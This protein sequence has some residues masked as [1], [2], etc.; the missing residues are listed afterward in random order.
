MLGTQTGGW[1]NGRCKWIHWAIVAPYLLVLP[2]AKHTKLVRKSLIWVTGTG[3]HYCCVPLCLI[4]WTLLKKN[5]LTFEGS[6]LNQNLFLNRWIEAATAKAKVGQSKSS[7]WLKQFFSWLRVVFCGRCV[8]PT[9]CTES[10]YPNCDNTTTQSRL[11]E[12]GLIRVQQKMASMAL[13]A[14]TFGLLALLIFVASC[15]LLSVST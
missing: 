12:I 4:R 15:L 7:I 1:Q 8:K 13:N 11:V 3:K 9:N 2:Y 10:N 5:W 6:E 14:S